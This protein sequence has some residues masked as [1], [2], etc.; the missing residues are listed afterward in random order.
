M[1]DR[2]VLI[3]LAS[4]LPKGSGERRAILAGLKKAN[5]NPHQVGEEKSG[6][7]EK[8]PDEGYLAGEFTQQEFQE[9]RQ[10]QEQGQLARRA[11]KKPAK[12]AWKTLQLIPGHRK[13]LT[14]LLAMMETRL[15]GDLQA[16]RPEDEGYDWVK[17]T[18]SG[19]TPYKERGING[20]RKMKGG[21]YIF[22]GTVSGMGEVIIAQSSFKV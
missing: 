12:I 18:Y 4:T 21:K 6:P 1:S 14:N 15:T 20:N 5:W 9:L 2:S 22:V 10:R 7:L 11:A 16:M 8:Q 17:A 3:R 13:N 19:G